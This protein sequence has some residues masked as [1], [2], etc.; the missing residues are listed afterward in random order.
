MKTIWLIGALAMAA[1]ADG[2][3][4]SK[5]G[6]PRLVALGSGVTETVIALGHGRELVG[7]D[8]TSTL[9]PELDGAVADLGFFRRI[10]LEG[11]VAVRPTR[12]LADS[13][14]GPEDVLT[15]LRA[16]SIDVVRLPA[17]DSIE[18]AIARLTAIAGAL[19]AAEAGESL[20]SRVRSDLDA[21]RAIAQV[22]TKR[23]RVLFVYAR[24]RSVLHVAGRD[25]AIGALL[26][27]AGAENA[28]ASL[29]GFAPLTAEAAI[30]ADPEIVVATTA[31]VASL[32]GEDALWKLPSLIATRA[33]RERRLVVH[34][35]S[36]LLGMGPRFGEA[37]K[38]LATSLHDTAAAPG[39][40][41]P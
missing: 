33:A 3:T 23:P 13:E 18:G 20:A 38:A 25:T 19:D 40:Q 4:P 36:F 34:D 39:A 9:P 2:E 31:G 14:V 1:G 10:S 24:G 12:V 28:A 35:D 32:G 8:S 41:R 21:A 37:A 6:T 29:E 26:E 17:A 30:G 15:R 22:A 27:V 7:V 11:V 16:A 5:V